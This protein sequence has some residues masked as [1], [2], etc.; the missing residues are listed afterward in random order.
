MYFDDELLSEIKKMKRGDRL[1][2]D[3][4]TAYGE[5]STA[6]DFGGL[7]IRIL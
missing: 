3:H 7:M 2:I 5:N 4:I 1:R 6:R